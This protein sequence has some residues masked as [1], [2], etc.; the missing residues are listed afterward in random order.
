[1]T[2]TPDVTPEHS[3]PRREGWLAWPARAGCV[4]L[5]EGALVVVVLVLVD[6]LVAAG[7]IALVSSSR[8]TATLLDRGLVFRSVSG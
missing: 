3:F 1:M 7:E 2:P 6:G 5:V 8:P 4:L